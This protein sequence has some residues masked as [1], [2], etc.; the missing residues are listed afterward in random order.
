MN[1]IK[2]WLERL[3]FVFLL[4]ALLICWLI[5]NIFGIIMIIIGSSL[6]F[7]IEL[8]I[9]IISLGMYDAKIVKYFMYLAENIFEYELGFL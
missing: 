7:C 4:L 9:I 8:P 2:D 3:L 6:F 1:Y 5:K